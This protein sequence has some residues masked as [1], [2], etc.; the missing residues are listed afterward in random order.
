MHFK[1][2]A[3]TEVSTN[4]PLV[5]EQNTDCLYHC[6]SRYTA[7]KNTVLVGGDNLEQET[8]NSEIS[9]AIRL[10]VHLDI[11]GYV[12]WIAMR[13][14]T[15]KFQ[16]HLDQLMVKRK[17]RLTWA[18]VLGVWDW[19]HVTVLAKVGFANVWKGPELHHCAQT[20]HWVWAAHWSE[21][22]LMVRCAT[23]FMPF[24]SPLVIN[25][26]CPFHWTLTIDF[27]LYHLQIKA[28]LI[29]WY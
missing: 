29:H 16:P 9:S 15:S 26:L 2:S 1:K 25:W 10:T 6:I 22:T 11:C 3:L 4:D 27:H 13:T 21:C 5:T 17:L 23:H 12:K 28:T 8:H 20:L 24:N 7:N 18:N 14:S 19:E